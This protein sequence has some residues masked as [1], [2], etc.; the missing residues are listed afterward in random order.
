MIFLIQL[1]CIEPTKVSI[2]SP[3]RSSF[4]THIHRQN[5]IINISRTIQEMEIKNKQMKMF[6]KNLYANMAQA[7]TTLGD[8]LDPTGNY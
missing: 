4:T 8:T 1:E 6:I 3:I 5:E 7:P 2:D